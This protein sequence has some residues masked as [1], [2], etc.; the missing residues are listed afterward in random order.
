[1]PMDGIVDILNH[2]H[3]GNSNDSSER[4]VS[5]PENIPG[6]QSLLI[7]SLVCRSLG[8]LRFVQSCKTALSVEA[9]PSTM[10]SPQ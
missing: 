8:E 6:C 5:P 9:D 1:M 7:T 2:Y 3:F 4:Y 10:T